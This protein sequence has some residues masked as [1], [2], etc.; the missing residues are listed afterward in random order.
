MEYN[1]ETTNKVNF[2][3]LSERLRFNPEI[4]LKI[5][6]ENFPAIPKGYFYELNNREIE[7]M[8]MLIYKYGEIKE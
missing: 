8:K 7:I 5:Y 1:I 4:L 6:Q 3:E 2:Y